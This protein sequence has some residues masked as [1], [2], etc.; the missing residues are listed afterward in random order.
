M[1][2]LIYFS[3]DHSSILYIEN[4][5]KIQLLK[6]SVLVQINIGTLVY[7]FQPDDPA[8]Q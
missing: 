3:A 7:D 8:V 2:L 6:K 5:S 1:H 4:S